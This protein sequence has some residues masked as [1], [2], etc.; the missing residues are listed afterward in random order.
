MV[1]R[2]DHPEAEGRAREAVR[3]TPSRMPNLRADLLVALAQ[4]LWAGGDG[5]DVTRTIGQAIH[6]D[7]REGSPDLPLE[8]VPSPTE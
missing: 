3:L 6:L 2:D 4:G 8:P 1:N 5:K 7:D